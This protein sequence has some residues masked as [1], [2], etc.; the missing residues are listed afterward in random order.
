MAL[1]IPILN[2]LNNYIKY[3]LYLSINKER[4]ELTKQYS[5]S[6]DHPQEIRI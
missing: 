5:G 1:Y 3:L 6:R 4:I 2:K